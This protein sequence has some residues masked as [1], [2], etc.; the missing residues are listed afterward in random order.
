[1]TSVSALTAEDSDDEDI[2]KVKINYYDECS[3]RGPPTRTRTSTL[4]KSDL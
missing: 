2:N 1:L 3:A 4:V